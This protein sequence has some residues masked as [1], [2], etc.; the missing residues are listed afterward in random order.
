M[1]TCVELQ[2]RVWGERDLE[3]VPNTVFI[4]VAQIGG[5]VLGAFAGAEMIG[6]TFA[7]PGVREGKPFLHSHMTALLEPY[8]DRGVGRRLKLFQ[9]EDALARG[10][11]MVEWTFDP[12]AT[13]NAHFN[14][15]RLGA[16]VRRAVRNAYGVTSSPMHRGLPTDR[17]VAE[18]HLDSPRVRQILGGRVAAPR[19]RVAEITVPEN[20]EDRNAVSLAEVA[21]I[22]DRVMAE[23]KSCFARGYT[24]VATARSPHGFKYILD[25]EF[26]PGVN[27]PHRKAVV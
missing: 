22:Q 6:F 3:I 25:A 20:I 14:L 26:S 19:G 13:R 5:Q 27:P 9:R 12:L 11:D 21:R 23:F 24:A 15:D 8:R 16:I 7:I 10:I 4:V 2:R 1:N 17:L 18:W